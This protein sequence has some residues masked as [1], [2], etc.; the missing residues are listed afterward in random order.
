MEIPGF[1]IERF[2]AEGG[3]ASVYLAIQESLQRP[4]ALKVLKKFDSPEHAKRFL[5][6]ARIVASLDHRNI[7]TIHDIGVVGD[8][9]YIAMEYLEGGSLADRIAKGMR[10]PDILDLVES[11]GGCLDFVH[12]RGIVHRDMKPGNVL[13]HADGTP[14]LTDFGIAKQLDNDPDLTM[15]GTSVGSPSYLS[16][17]QAGGGPLDGRSDI[18]ALGVVFFEMLTGRKPY[19]EGSAIETILAHLTHPI[20]ILP[21]ALSAY[22]GLLERMLAKDPN[23]R[24]ASAGEFVGRVRE[25]RTSAPRPPSGAAAILAGGW[26]ADRLERLAA[27]GIQRLRASG[28]AVKAAL[29]LSALSVAAGAIVLSGQHG[30]RQDGHAKGM[31]EPVPTQTSGTS[32]AASAPA[33]TTAARPAQGQSPAPATAQVAANPQPPDSPA[34]PVEPRGE[35]VLATEESSIQP[36]APHST[37]DSGNASARAMDRPPR[38]AGGVE[39]VSATSSQPLEA[40]HGPGGEIEEE[41]VERWLLAAD[42]ALQKYRLTTPPQDNAYDYYQRVIKL[43]PHQEEAAAGIHKIAHR[44]AVL[45]R[46]E[47][48]R[49]NYPLARRYVRR[50]IAV[51]S[52]DAELLAL[53]AQINARSRARTARQERRGEERRRNHESRT[54]TEKF[55]RDF[56]ALKDGV[57]KAWHSMF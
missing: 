14:K 8:R 35:G 48:N 56:N 15:D 55:E 26:Q 13:F 51:R 27:G 10:L 21:E 46:T 40:A 44:Y 33:E 29:A 37:P 28:L 3:M 34:G 11:I 1:K 19:A 42:R 20:P 24:I 32:E 2:I 45:A 4:V 12:R 43:D 18:Y 54:F 5:Y 17:E 25:L 31:V 6:E 16:P 53:R 50:G 39:P 38:A 41:A 9:H 57:K 36:S 49:G 22:Q 52:D 7:T 23:D 30:V 47:L